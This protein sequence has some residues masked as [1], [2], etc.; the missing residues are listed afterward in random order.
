[1][2]R[3][4]NVGRVLL[5]DPSVCHSG[6]GLPGHG[7]AR[8]AWEHLRVHGQPCGGAPA[9]APPPWL[10]AAGFWKSSTQAPPL[11]VLPASGVC[12]PGAVP[13]VAPHFSPC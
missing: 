5:W 4:G 1:M 7:E 10:G 3:W 2:G 12:F 6:K 11:A 8:L 9:P 13:W